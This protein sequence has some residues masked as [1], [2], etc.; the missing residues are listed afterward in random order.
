MWCENVKI[1]ARNLCVNDNS[2][3]GFSC[4]LSKIQFSLEYIRSEF[5][6]KCM[7]KELKRLIMIGISN[8]RFFAHIRWLSCYFVVVG[9]YT[10]KKFSRLF[11]PF[12]LDLFAPLKLSSEYMNSESCHFSFQMLFIFSV[13]YVCFMPADRRVHIHS[14]SLWKWLYASSRKFE[15]KAFLFYFFL[16][17]SEK[18]ELAW[19]FS[20][21]Y[22]PPPICMGLAEN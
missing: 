6:L 14:E 13:V 2:I 17:L 1:W 7:M 3:R 10:G 8:I 18:S 20:E 9:I 5:E 11:Q 4:L 21:K 15:L 22:F 12:L 19:E 16:P